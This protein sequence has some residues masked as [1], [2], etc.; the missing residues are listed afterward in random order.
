MIFS[1]IKFLEN[2]LDSSNKLKAS[3]LEQVQKILDEDPEAMEGYR[4]S[5]A[6]DLTSNKASGLNF[7]PH[8]DTEIST[9]KNDEYGN[10]NGKAY[11][12]NMFS[13]DTQNEDET[14]LKSNTMRAF[15][16]TTEE[17]FMK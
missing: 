7:L 12:S 14:N 13:P 5:H 15:R 4:I 10:G 9:N 11:N 6:E 17:P 3:Y 2:Q 8:R 16:N 1:Y